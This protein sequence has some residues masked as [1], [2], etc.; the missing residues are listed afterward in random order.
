MRRKQHELVSIF[1]DESPLPMDI[2]FLILEISGLVYN[3]RNHSIFIIKGVVCPTPTGGAESGDTDT[4]K[5]KH[6][7]NDPLTPMDQTPHEGVP[8]EQE[9]RSG[10]CYET[11]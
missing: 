7:V 8:T 6:V 9:G 4:V 3:S 11:G 10:S 1:T 5:P 2:L